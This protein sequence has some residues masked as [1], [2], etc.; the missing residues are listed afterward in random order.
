MITYKFI[1]FLYR[2]IKYSK[3]LNK[4]YR[5]ENLIENLSNLFGVSF[6]KDWIGR[7]YTI[8]NPNLIKEKYSTDT[9]IFEYNENGLNNSIYIEKWIM[10]KLNIASQFIQTNNLF[11]LL[12]YEIKKIDKFDNYLFIIQPITLSECLKW[13]KIF[14]IMVT[15]IFMIVGTLIII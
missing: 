12:T 7:I 1:K 8:L 14:G 9:Q 2:N 13:S 4:A 6:K 3:I 11:D 10:D 5:D 15:I